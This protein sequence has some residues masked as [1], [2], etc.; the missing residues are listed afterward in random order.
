MKLNMPFLRTPY[1]YDRDAAS[2]ESGLACMDET[3]TIQSQAEDTDINVIMARYAKTGMLPEV[4]LPPTYGDFDQVDNYQDA[5]HLVMEAQKAFDKLAPEIRRKFNY[6]PGQFVDF[7]ENPQNI[8][9]MRRM[10]LAKA[11][12]AK[13]DPPPATPPKGVEEVTQGK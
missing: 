12:E 7:A 4:P 1:N 11:L 8:E 2:N 6:D 3:R 10:G 9:E 13:I 5:L